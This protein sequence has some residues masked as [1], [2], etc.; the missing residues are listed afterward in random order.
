MNN[1]SSSQPS[2][3]IPE[4][5]GNCSK[6]F[7]GGRFH[8]NHPTDQLD[9]LLISQNADPQKCFGPSKKHFNQLTTIGTDSSPKPHIKAN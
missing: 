6:K 8:H 9:H 2:F 5:D 1:N 4:W 7:K 3:S